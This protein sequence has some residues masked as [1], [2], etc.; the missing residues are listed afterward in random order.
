MPPAPRWC[1]QPTLAGVAA[2]KAAPLRWT[3]PAKPMWRGV[4]VD[5]AANAYVSGFTAS[6]DF[7]TASPLQATNAGGPSDAFVTKLNAAGTALVF[8]TYLGGNGTE[9]GRKIAVD[10]AGNAYVGG[11]TDSTNFP[12]ARPLQ[13]AN[14]GGTSDAIVAKICND[15]T[16]TPGT[17]SATGSMVTGRDVNSTTFFPLLANGKVLIAGGSG[18]SNNLPTDSAELYDVTTGSFTATGSLATARTNHTLTRLSNGKV[19]VAGGQPS[20]G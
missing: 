2:I 4:A 5:A 19:L 10:A 12:T 3:P 15:Q 8:S 18:S 6:T 20:L 13:A 9:S 14:G 11:L 17:W 16:G 7:P 1:I